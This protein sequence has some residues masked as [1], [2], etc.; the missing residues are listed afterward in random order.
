MHLL[1]N[2]HII[3]FVIY[4]QAFMS[5]MNGIADGLYNYR[6]SFVLIYVIYNDSVF[7]PKS[8]PKGGS[9][10]NHGVCRKS[11]EGKQYGYPY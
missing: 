8:L 3:S 2:P 10:E 6:F 5:A 9:N 4:C 11:T 7:N 1:K